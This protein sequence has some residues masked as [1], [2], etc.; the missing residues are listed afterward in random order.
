MDERKLK[1][2]IDEAEVI[3]FDVFDTLLFR[4]TARPEAIFELMGQKIG[5]ADFEDFRRKK[6]QEISEI[7]VKRKEAPHA[8]LDQIYA[9]IASQDQS[10]DWE[11]VK[12]LEIQME[13]DAVFQNTEIY[14]WYQY[15]VQQKKRIIATSDMYLGGQQIRRMIEKCGYTDIANVYSS[16][17]LKC[18]KYEKTIFSAVAKQERVQGKKILHIGDNKKADVENARESGWNSFWYERRVGEPEKVPGIF[19]GLLTKCS[20]DATFWSRL[21]GDAAGELYINLYRWVSGLKKR[22]GCEQI[23]LLARDGFNLWKIFRNMDRTDTLYLEVSRRSLMMAGITELDDESL[24]ILPPYALGQTLG[25]IL[26]Y[27]GLPKEKLDCRKAGFQS[28]QD[29][30]QTKEDQRRVKQVFQDNEKEFLAACEKEREEAKAYSAG[31]GVLGRNNLF[32]DCGWNGSSQFLMSRFYRA[33]GQM[34]SVRFA[35]VG[36][37]DTEK[38]RRQLKG[39][40]FDTYLFGPGKHEKAAMRLARAIVIPELFFGAPHPSIWYYR[41]GKAVYEQEQY[42]EYKEQI[43]EGIAIYF[44][45]VYP[46]VQKYGVSFEKRDIFA[47]LLR[48]CEAPTKEEAVRIGNIENIDGFVRQMSMKKYIA[49]LD[50]KTIR[51]NPHI[52]IYWERGLLKRP[53]ISASVKTFVVVKEFLTKVKRRLGR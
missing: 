53:D 50:L 19:S 28:L 8:D 43:A 25:E 30:I 45:K 29:I 17:D 16:A 2:L 7:L 26:E 32:F 3:S 18:T 20:E 24:E 38:S 34:E 10:R 31:L 44:S 22:Y 52:E 11:R 13:L 42:Q 51:R 47:S 41:D 48:L 9:Y 5:M 12:D 1:Q 33:I 27:L 37:L 14:R 39:Q 36:I 21:G 4:I 15:A 46:F 23:C 40:M 35:Y 6:Q 49:R